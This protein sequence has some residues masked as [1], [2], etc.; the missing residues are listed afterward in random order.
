[1]K[2]ETVLLIV[3]AV[4]VAGVGFYLYSRAGGTQDAPPPSAS[5]R[6]AAIDG[7]AQSGTDLA[8]NI[9]GGI[10]EG[11]GLVRDIYTTENQR[12]RDAASRQS[13][14]G[15]VREGVA[16][17]VTDSIQDPT[18][19]SLASSAAGPIGTL[20]AGSF[21]RALEEELPLP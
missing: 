7:S 3:G 16:A 12:A 21:R 8:G 20:L 19:R 17:E 18:L 5:D 10:R 4:A 11:L 1:M 6:T 9:V 14:A 15:Y 2:T 13:A